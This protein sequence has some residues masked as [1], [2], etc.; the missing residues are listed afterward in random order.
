[1]NISKDIY[2]LCLE[3][4]TSICSVAL[5]KNGE[6]IASKDSL[7]GQKHSRWMT[8]YVQQ[9]LAEANLKIDQLHAVAV[10]EGPGSYT[11]LRV[12]YSIAKGICYRL[13]IPII[14]IPTLEALGTSFKVPTDETHV[15]ISAIDARRMEVYWRIINDKGSCLKETEAHIYNVTSFDSYAHVD[16]IYVVGDG[17]EKINNMELDEHIKGKIY[18]KN[19]L[20]YATNL[21][22]LAFY[23]YENGLFGDTAYS[24]PFYLKSPNITTPKKKI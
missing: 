11:G 17:A 20:T 23:K 15:I 7:E 12:G 2:I 16:R 22:K 6:T 19:H 9:L 3:S 1:M 21:S 4:S 5:C 14:E 24:T 13:D 10:S 8:V 18:I